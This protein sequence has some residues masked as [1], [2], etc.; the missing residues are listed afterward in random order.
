MNRLLLKTRH[1]LIN[2]KRDQYR[3]IYESRLVKKCYKNGIY[4]LMTRDFR[5]CSKR[6]ISYLYG[7][8]GLDLVIGSYFIAELILKNCSH[9]NIHNLYRY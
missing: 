3:K 4:S 7:V 1:E 5:I 2:A 9:N 8:E 6:A